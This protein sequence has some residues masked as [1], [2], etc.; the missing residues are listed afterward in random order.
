MR[1]LALP[2][3]D[4]LEEKRLKMRNAATRGLDRAS[5]FHI[6]LIS[7]SRRR[8]R[9]SETFVSESDASLLMCL[10]HANLDA[11]GEELVLNK[12]IT[13]PHRRSFFLLGFVAH[14][15]QSCLRRLDL[16]F[17]AGNFWAGASRENIMDPFFRA[18][19]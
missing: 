15:L 7:P 5:D 8:V 19:F 13:R 3:V 2:E 12:E 10:V 6:H 11:L 16:S 14:H 17:C 4:L 1:W 18:N 9:N